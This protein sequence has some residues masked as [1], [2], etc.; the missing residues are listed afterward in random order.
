MRIMRKD[1]AIYGRDEGYEE[2]QKDTACGK[3]EG[4][5]GYEENMRVM[6]KI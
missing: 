6:R 2:K 4:Y 5:E 3:Y 1:R